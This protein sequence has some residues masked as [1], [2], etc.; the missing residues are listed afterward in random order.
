MASRLDLTQERVEIISI[1][2]SWYTRI[3]NLSARKDTRA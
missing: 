2:Q 1:A 3:V